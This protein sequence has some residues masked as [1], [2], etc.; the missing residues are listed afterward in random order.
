MKRIHALATSLLLAAGVAQAATVHS[1][2]FESGNKSAGWSG[3]GTVQSTGSFA[4]LG[5]GEQHLRVE[6]DSAAVLT[7]NN[8]GA[9]S[10]LTLSFDL[11][12]WDSID[13]NAGGFPYGDLFQLRA[14]NVTMI[15]QLFGNYGTNGS[16]GPGSTLV[17]NDANR[18]YGGWVDSARRVQLTF[19]HSADTVRFEFR[20]PNSQGSSDESFGLDNLQV[21]ITPVPEPGSWALLLGGLGLVGLA[22]RRRV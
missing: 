17:Q 1:E 10:T 9:H 22:S 16:E 21:S 12:L 8:L 5:F 13:G 2:D 19:A 7:L 15:E 11:V 4:S 20:Y 14:D 6:G 18:G 3:A